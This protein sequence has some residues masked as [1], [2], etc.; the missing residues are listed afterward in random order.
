[1][2]IG[3]R[4]FL[5][6]GDHVSRVSQKTFDEFFTQRKPVLRE[7]A[8]Q[9]VEIATVIYKL[10]NRKPEQVIRVDCQRFKVKDDGSIDED[11]DHEYNRLMVIRLDKGFQGNNANRE[12][13]VV[14]ARDRFE[15]RRLEH[16]HCPTL[17]AS[18]VE[19]IARDLF[20]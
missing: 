17:S 3:Y 4:I 12:T 6:R 13:N 19:R 14:D 10:A 2:S 16:K 7:F 11:H 20:G 5:V 8:G 1:M 15:E 18:A 9:N